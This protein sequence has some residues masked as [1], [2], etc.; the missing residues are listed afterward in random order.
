MNAL[1]TVH[2][3]AAAWKVTPTTIANCFVKCAVSC[4]TP[5]CVEE[6]DPQ[7]DDDFK[8]LDKIY[9]GLDVCA[10]CYEVATCGIQL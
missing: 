6:D 3:I 7:F 5:S 8:K 10:S 9:V 4:E 1:Q 2:Y